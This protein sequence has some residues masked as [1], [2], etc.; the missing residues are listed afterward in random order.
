MKQLLQTMEKQ[1]LENARILLESRGIPVF[2]GNEHS[3]NYA[4]LASP[5][6]QLLLW[7]V[8][9]EQWPDAVA[10]LRDEN[11][12]VRAPVDV[13]E[14]YR[15]AEEQRRDTARALFDRAMLLLVLIIAAFLALFFAVRLLR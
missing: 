9:D 1:E 2:V 7:V 15:Q 10:L 14:F 4:G 6:R 5:A 12:E 11:H 13:A 8:L 3:A